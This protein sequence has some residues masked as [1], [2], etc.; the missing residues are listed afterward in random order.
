MTAKAFNSSCEVAASAL[1]ITPVTQPAE[2]NKETR[3]PYFHS[4]QKH[5]LKM[6]PI[7][8]ALI[9]LDRTISHGDLTASM[10]GKCRP[11][12]KTGRYNIGKNWN[13]LPQLA[14][15]PPGLKLRCS[16]DVYGII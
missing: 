2:R 1:A 8:S 10:D 6:V 12:I 9:L 16:D 5:D 13:F 4:F 7:T 14:S 15:D 3:E 11:P